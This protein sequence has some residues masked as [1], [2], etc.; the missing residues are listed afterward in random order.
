MNAVK[1][2]LFHPGLRLWLGRAWRGRDG[3]L[4]RTGRVDIFSVTNGAGQVMHGFLR[5]DWRK[6]AGPIVTGV[7]RRAVGFPRTVMLGVVELLIL[8]GGIGLVLWLVLCLLQRLL[9]T[10]TGNNWLLVRC[11]LALHSWLLAHS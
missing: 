2:I 11:N 5:Y 1:K 3:E 6:P 10:P 4:P 8:G 7:V 9:L